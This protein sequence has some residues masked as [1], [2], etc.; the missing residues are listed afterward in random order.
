M[1]KQ[2]RSLSTDT[3]YTCC[4]LRI[5]KIRRKGKAT[6]DKMKRGLGKFHLRATL[7]CYTKY[8][9]ELLCGLAGSLRPP[10]GEDHGI[11]SVQKLV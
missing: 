3:L 4:A 10:V 6:K 9:P 2:S 7:W 11:D 5:T 8:Q 1:K